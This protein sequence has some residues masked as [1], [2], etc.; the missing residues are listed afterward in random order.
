MELILPKVIAAGIF[1][2]NNS[3]KNNTSPN[4]RVTMFEIELPIEDGGISFVDEKNAEIKKD[5][6]IVVHPN[7]IRH[8][9]LPF[10]CYYIHLI[11]NKGELSDTLMNMPEFIDLAKSSDKC[12]K[13]FKDIIK[14]YNSGLSTDEIKLHS[15]ILDLIHLLTKN[16]TRQILEHQLSSNYN[17]IEE[18][19]EYIK[20]NLESDLSLATLSKRANF[21][22]V[23]FHNTFK[24]ATGMTLRQFVEDQRIKR[25]TNLLLTTD[26]TLT[27][28]AYECGFTSQSYFSFAFKRKM[29]ITP[30]DYV[31][32]VIS[33]YDI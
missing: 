21:S 28:I 1:K 26:F 10:S 5:R 31:K 17:V 30:R 33:K 20:R 16:S 27:Q 24:K 19:V 32:D 29:N 18:S 7:Q 11:I 6:A 13:I 12:K 9:K 23:H 2:A 8:T 3:Y 25:A 14:F 15:L 22:E 4:R